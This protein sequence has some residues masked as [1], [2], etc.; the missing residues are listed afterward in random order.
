MKK[1]LFLLVFMPLCSIAQKWD[2][3]INTGVSVISEPGMPERFFKSEMTPT[4]AVMISVGRLIKP[5]LRLGLDLDFVRL[6]R[7]TEFEVTD[8]TGQT[9]ATFSDGR[10]C[11]G[12]TALMVSPSL[13]YSI[14]NFYF[15]GQVGYLLTTEGENSD[16]KS[17]GRMYMNKAQGF[18]GGLQAGYLHKIN[19]R[20]S[21]NAE[22]RGNY[23]DAD[24]DWYT[25]FTPT[26]R[27]H[28]FQV[29]AMVG[30]RYSL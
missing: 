20:F 28:A 7:K 21:L 27:L 1:Y 29:Q 11:I 6:W 14:R 5:R 30:L 25:T 8:L 16:A 15:G 22:L 26:Y 3:G 24:A 23:F 9:I 12:N 4:P 18:F 19:R 13:T 10:F 2:V 17:T